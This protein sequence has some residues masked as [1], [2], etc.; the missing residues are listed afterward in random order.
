MVDVI[1][2]VGSVVIIFGMAVVIGAWLAGAGPGPL[3]HIP[4]PAALTLTG[5]ILLASVGFATIGETWMAVAFGLWGAAD[6]LM[7][8]APGLPERVNARYDLWG[9]PH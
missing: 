5:G 7:L 8:L 2:T 3:S 4:R 6:L 1:Q 9:Q